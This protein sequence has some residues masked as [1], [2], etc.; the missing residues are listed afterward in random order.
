MDRR[1]RQS[2]AQS[3]PAA[4]TRPRNR[5][6]ARPRTSCAGPDTFA[7]QDPDIATEEGRIDLTIGKPQDALVAFGRALALDPGNAAAY[8]NRGVALL[9]LGQRE[10]ARADFERALKIDPGQPDARLN[11]SRLGYDHK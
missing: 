8:N 6:T 2:S 9:M 11:L 7:P 5:W 3:P 4:A 10:A 1:R